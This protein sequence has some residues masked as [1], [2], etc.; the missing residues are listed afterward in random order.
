MTY[1]LS[2]LASINSCAIINDGD[3]DFGEIAVSDLTDECKQVLE[4]SSQKIDRSTLAHLKPKQQQ[5]LWQ[6]LDRYADRFSDLPSLT[7]RAE[8][9]VELLPGFK[10]KRMRAYKV[11]KRLRPEVVLM[12]LLLLL[13]LMTVHVSRHVVNDLG[14]EHPIAFFSSKLTPAQRNWATIEREAYAVLVAE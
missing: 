6:L 11:P 13:I 1:S 9:C 7:K 8:H 14:V 10:P 12:L 3:D 5:E 4:L 2:L